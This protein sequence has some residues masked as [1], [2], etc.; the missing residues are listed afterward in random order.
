MSGRGELRSREKPVKGAWLFGND[1]R[2]RETQEPLDDPAGQVDLVSLDP[3]AGYGPGGACARELLL[4]DPSRP[5][6]LIPCPK[7]GSSQLDWARNRSD[8]SLYG[9]LLKR[10]EACR[11]AGHLR[12]LL[13]YQGE[14]EAANAD[15]ARTWGDRFAV[16]AR[17]LRADL[18][19]PRLPV[20][21]AQLAT[22][23]DGEHPA[24]A[25]VQQR[26]AA[27]RLP[28]CRMVPTADLP[29]GPDG[30]H[31]TREA[32]QVLGRRFAEALL[33]EESEEP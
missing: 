31:L 23:R 4:R 2:W 13:W 15:L 25:Q 7:G 18:R 28:R 30:I 8:L 12:A 1:Y 16:F 9:S 27:V 11:P 20:V 33:A 21:Y 14:A 10:A 3:N 17:Q 5:L 22:C 32:Q 19:D 24:W 26:Q 6:G 29:V